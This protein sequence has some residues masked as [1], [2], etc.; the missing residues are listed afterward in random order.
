[1]AQLSLQLLRASSLPSR[2]DSDAYCPLEF[3]YGREY[4]N[5]TFTSQWK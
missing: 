2:V 1:M 5:A 4:L 3:Q